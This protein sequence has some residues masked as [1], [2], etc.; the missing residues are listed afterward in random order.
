MGVGRGWREWSRLIPEALG[1]GKEAG[2]A[3]TSILLSMP[4]GDSIGSFKFSVM[5][6]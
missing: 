3:V 2:P 5:R 1:A 6:E 4:F